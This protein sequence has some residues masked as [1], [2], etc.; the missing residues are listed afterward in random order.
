MQQDVVKAMERK[1][2]NGMEREEKWENAT[3]GKERKN[4]NEKSNIE[5]GS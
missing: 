5:D 3:K 1:E 2:N 4:L